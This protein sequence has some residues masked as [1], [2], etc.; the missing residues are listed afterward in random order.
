MHAQISAASY[1]GLTRASI[2]LRKMDCR[3]KPGNDKGKAMRSNLRFGVVALL[4]LL[5]TPL[6]ASART[7]HIVAFG[8][9]ATGGW[10][11]AKK[12]AYPAQLEA[13]LRA[14]GY[15]VRVRNAGISG[16]TTAGALK[17]LDQAIDP[18]TD[19][20]I[21]EFGT[22]DLRLHRPMSA[23]RASLTEIIRTLRK[24]AIQVLLAG[25]GSL[26]LSA[27]AKENGV[28]YAQ[29]KLPPG[30]YR[31]RDGQHF[32]AQGYAIVVA[33]MLPAIEA[34]MKRVRR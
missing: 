22:N 28:T 3:V 12:D 5:A 27:V 31:A 15:D 19:I 32:N 29:W 2:L 16:D 8:D 33:R 25:L 1:P 20:A 11:V 10:L 30:K 24:R 14:K 4:I 17:R 7:I 26:D 9:S 18:D 23:V 34:M 6:P 21:V 13:T